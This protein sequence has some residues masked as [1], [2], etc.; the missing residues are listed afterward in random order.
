M[1]SRLALSLGLVMAACFGSAAE[2]Q[3]I[4]VP[5]GIV[6]LLSDPACTVGF[7]RDGEGPQSLGWRWTGFDSASGVYFVP[8]ARDGGHE[9]FMHCPWRKGPG[10]AYADFRLRLPQTKRIRLTVSTALR[11]TAA[12]S[13]GVT[14]PEP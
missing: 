9:V 13:D 2:Q 1:V 3:C 12:N 8:E 4:D 5:V 11:R 6:D 7:Q 14:Y 10:V